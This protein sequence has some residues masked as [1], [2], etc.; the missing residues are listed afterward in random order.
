MVLKTCFAWSEASTAFLSRIAILASKCNPLLLRVRATIVMVGGML[1]GR[2]RLSSK[3]LG[4]E[5]EDAA[6]T[7]YTCS[8]NIE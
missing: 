5:G 1:V 2:R 6:S 7:K 3:G 4:N 8:A